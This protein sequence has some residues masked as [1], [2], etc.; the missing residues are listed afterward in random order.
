MRRIL[1][2]YAEH[3]RAAKR[4]GDLQRVTLCESQASAEHPAFDVDLL[5]LDEALTD[6]ER[7][8][9]RQCR[10]VELR[11]FSGM[12]VEEAAAALGVSPRLVELDWKMARAWL[13]Q[14]LHA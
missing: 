8:D 12:S 5:A 10:V 4:G 11:F 9:A 3:H 1:I 2:N 14:R 6:L 13:F 7:L